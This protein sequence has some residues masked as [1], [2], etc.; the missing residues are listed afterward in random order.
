MIPELAPRAKVSRAT[1]PLIDSKFSVI[2]GLACMYRHMHDRRD[3][4]DLYASSA[5]AADNEPYL[6][7][8]PTLKTGPLVTA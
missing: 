6:S 3:S 1:G 2:D 7:I 4:E 5:N 8:E